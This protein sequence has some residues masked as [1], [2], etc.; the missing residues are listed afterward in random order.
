MVDKRWLLERIKQR[1]ESIASLARAV[2][3]DRAVVH[4]IIEGDQPLQLWMTPILA[5]KLG[6]TETELLS[7]SGELSL[8]PMSA[9]PVIPWHSVGTFS[10][11]KTR[12]ELSPNYERIMVPMTSETLIALKVSDKSMEGIFPEGSTIVVDYSEKD[13]RDNEI[14][15]FA[16]ADRCVLRRYRVQRRKPYLAAE[17]LDGITEEEF[18]GEIVG[19]V[20]AA[21]FISRHA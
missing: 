15:V 7:R 20:V 17:G 3:R 16:N 6:V 19:R 18:A 2:G 5:E 21:P 13:I 8:P 12:I 4:R 9:A 1:G 14:G 10:L 11:T